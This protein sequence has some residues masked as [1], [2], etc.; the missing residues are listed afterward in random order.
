MNE[1]Y[2][3]EEIFSILDNLNKF[4]QS[5]IP[6]C[7]AENVIS[8]FCKL[9][10]DGDIQE[11]Y[12]MGNYYTYSEKIILL[13]AS[14]LFPYMNKFIMYASYYLIQDIQMQGR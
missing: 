6:L 7:A 4:Q 13:E 8:N 10:L 11:R 12:I 5:R 2:N 3:F 14:I 9:P 1:L